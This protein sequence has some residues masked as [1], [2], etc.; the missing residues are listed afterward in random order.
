[1]AEVSMNPNA[2]MP[3]RRQTPI[4]R[5]GEMLGNAWSGIRET[6]HRD[7]ETGGLMSYNMLKGHMRNED[8]SIPTVQQFK[9]AHRVIWTVSGALGAFPLAD[10]FG[11]IAFGTRYYARQTDR[12]VSLA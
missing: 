11:S 8:G 12:G 9:T 5:A 10:P 6:F 4:Q 7:S 2:P 3:E 1:M